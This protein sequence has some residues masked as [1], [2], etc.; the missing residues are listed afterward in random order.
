MKKEKSLAKLKKDAWAVF[1]KY[2][3]QK[4]SDWK[5]DAACV[6]CG[7]VRP[8]KEMQ[9]G[10][11]I[12]G[13][14]N[15]ILFDERNVHVQCDGCNRWKQGNTVKYFRFMQQ[16]YGD[17]TIKELEHLDTLSHPF[18]RQEL[19][20]IIEKYAQQPAHSVSRDSISF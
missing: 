17:E 1:S 19:L 14:H 3:R 16:K 5:G 18:T 8:W 7:V 10:H 9:A 4:Y 15:S 12:P 11:F 6:T 20:E 2:I 13:R